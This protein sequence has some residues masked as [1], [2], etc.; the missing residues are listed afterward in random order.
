MADGRAPRPPLT[1]PR[2][3]VHAPELLD[4]PAQAPA[5][6]ERSLDDV[7]AVNRWL[8]GSRSIR[9]VLRPLLARGPADLLDI[10]AGSGE[11][12][13]SLRGWAARRGTDLRIIALD[14]G[15]VAVRHARA[16]LSAPPAGTAAAEQPRGARPSSS[17][18]AHVV[19]GD[20]CAL[21][22][23]DGALDFALLALTLHHFGEADAVGALAEAGR[24]A[25]RAVIVAELERTWPHYL[26]ARLLAATLWRRNAV[27]RHDAPISVLR[28]FTAAE[29]IDVAR[30]AGLRDARVERCAFYR[31]VLV[32][33]G[34]ALAATAT[35]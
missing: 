23:A 10:G 27:T 11:L 15:A 32:A 25:R 22:F 3:P 18:G 28:G 33:G 26:G 16:L 5:N 12:A 30:A 6:L 21:P 17:A 29:L 8:G 7:Y 35:V 13:L 34:A 31:L 4:D 9:R 20:A 14:R 1:R 24:V 2:R 19:R